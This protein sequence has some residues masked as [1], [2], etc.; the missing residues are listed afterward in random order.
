MA[1]IRPFTALRFDPGVVGDWG[2][3]LGPPYDVINDVQREALLGSSPYQISHVETAAGT[4][5]IAAAAERFAQWQRDGALIRDQHPAFYLAEDAF[6]HDG[7][8]RTRTCLYAAVRLTPWSDGDVLAHEWT[9]PGPKSIRVSLRHTVRADISPLMSILPDRSGHIAASLEPFRNLPLAADGVDANGER[10]TLRVIDDVAATAAL[11]AALA[12]EPIYMADG[13]HRYESALE[14]RDQIAAEA[15]SAW[16]DD[17]PENFVLMG[18]ILASDP[19]LIIG[20][21]HRLVHVAAPA[22]ALDQL[23]EHFTVGA[24]TGTT[25]SEL[26]AEIAAAGQSGVVMAVAGLDGSAA[27]ILT[28]KDSASRA[29]PDHVPASWA[30]LGAALLQYV[31]LDPIFGID[32]AALAAGEAVTYPHDESAA[33]AAVQSGQATAAFFLNPPTLD[34][35]FASADA[36]DRMPQKSTFF[37]PKLPTGVVLHTFD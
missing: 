16:S 10:H 20:S 1:D 26:L 17:Q 9:M 34:Q 27:H 31:V 7:Q 5:A 23:A 15:G 19:G 37:T 8:R 13:H 12:T 36:G 18:L 25:P 24:A 14:D 30:A 33:F 2:A 6:E 11:Q 28:A 32:D 22:D 35:T 21:A 3:V 4:A 29:L